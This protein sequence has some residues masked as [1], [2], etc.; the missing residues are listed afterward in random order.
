MVGILLS[1][2]GGLFSGA[3]LVSGRVY[4]PIWR[5]EILLGV[6]PV[7][8]IQ[9]V[10]KGMTQHEHGWFLLKELLPK[11]RVFS[12]S[13]RKVV[14]TTISLYKAIMGNIY[15]YMKI[16]HIIIVS[17]DHKYML[18]ILPTSRWLQMLSMSVLYYQ[19][20]PSSQ[21]P[22]PPLP[23][24]SDGDTMWQLQLV[25]SSP[26]A[27][28]FPVPVFQWQKLRA[29]TWHVWKKKGTTKICFVISGCDW[30]LWAQENIESIP[31]ED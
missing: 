20:H 12:V 11:T 18:L 29:N 23:K 30:R 19:A 8:L 3:T 26:T 2:W 10:A 6:K 28:W 17:M 31:P 7:K 25:L 9:L 1:Y 24:R 22:K 5:G 27:C 4:C 21:N 16:W 13:G 14:G 15:I